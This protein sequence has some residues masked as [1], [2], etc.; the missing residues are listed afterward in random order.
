MAERCLR[1]DRRPK[2]TSLTLKS[3][4]SRVVTIKWCALMPKR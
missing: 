4:G 1:A 2:A 3:A